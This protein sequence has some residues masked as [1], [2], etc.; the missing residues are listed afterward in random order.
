MDGEKPASSRLPCR[1]QEKVTKTKTTLN[2]HC[3]RKQP[4]QELKSPM[5][6]KT[7]VRIVRPTRRPFASDKVDERLDPRVGTTDSSEV[8]SEDG[9]IPCIIH[10]LETHIILGPGVQDTPTVQ[11]SDCSIQ[12]QHV[13]L[14]LGYLEIETLVTPAHHETRAI[15]CFDDFNLLPSGW[16]KTQ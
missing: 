8:V 11:Q 10:I 6:F 3:T 4:K 5:I 14:G 16:M 7:T 1:L 12:L 15:L 13:V 2:M 9:K